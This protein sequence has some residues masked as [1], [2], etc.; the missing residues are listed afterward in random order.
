V[1]LT[2]TAPA[3]DHEAERKD[4]VSTLTLGG[5]RDILRWRGFEGGFGAAVTFYAVPE[6]LK[7]SYGNVRCRGSS[8]FACVRRP[9]AGRMWNMTMARPMTEHTMDHMHGR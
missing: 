6:A 2:D 5:V 1:L 7:P 9:A 3:T 4:R 8:T